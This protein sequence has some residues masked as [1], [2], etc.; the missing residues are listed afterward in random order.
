MQPDVAAISDRLFDDIA[1][2]PALWV[3]N[4]NEAAWHRPGL[5]SYWVDDAGRDDLEAALGVEMDGRLLSIGRATGEHEGEYAVHGTMWGHVALGLLSSRGF[6]G[7]RTQLQLLLFPGDSQSGR[8]VQP[9]LE[10]NVSVI[11][12]PLSPPANAA[13]FLDVVA[14]PVPQ[15]YRVGLPQSTAQARLAEVTSAHRAARRERA[16]RRLQWMAE[17]RAEHLARR[18]SRE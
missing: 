5:L 1:A 14:P 15:L 6:H 18:A 8:W 3:S 16:E 12:V 10:A 13:R 9:W 2:R 4:D 7:L 17:V 11:G